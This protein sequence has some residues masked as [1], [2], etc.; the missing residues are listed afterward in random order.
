MQPE[1][2]PP[3]NRRLLPERAGA[4]RL[5]YCM[6]AAKRARRATRAVAEAETAWG[7]SEGG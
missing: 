5:A 2:S 7:E 1:G 3:T 4:Q 6:R